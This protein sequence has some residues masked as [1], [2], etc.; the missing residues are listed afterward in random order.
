MESDDIKIANLNDEDIAVIRAL[1]K[2]LGKDICLV[3]V[4]KKEVIYALEAKLKPN[5]WQRVDH[6]YPS[7]EGLKAYYSD[8]EVAKDSKNSLKSY[9][10]SPKAKRLVKKYPLRIRQ[11][12]HTQE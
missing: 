11:I 7:I 3:A 9:L 1:E 4:N 12:V 8:Y 2:K 6:T 5:H 10:S